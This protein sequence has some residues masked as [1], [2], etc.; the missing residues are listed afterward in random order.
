MKKLLSCLHITLLLV[1]IVACSSTPNTIGTAISATQ[2]A[3]NTAAVISQQNTLVA[4]ANLQMTQ[5]AAY[6]ILE[7]TH[8]AIDQTQSAL[9]SQQQ[10]QAA[11]AL[12]Q[13]V[14]M[15][16]PNPIPSL[17]AAGDTEATPTPPPGV[18][19][20]SSTGVDFSNAKILYPP[21]SYLGYNKLL[22]SIGLPDTVTNIP[23]KYHLEVAEKLFT[24]KTDVK[25]PN[26]LF[27][28]GN[29]P[30]G[31]FHA[32][33]LYED[34]G[35]VASLVFVSSITSPVWTPTFVRG[36]PPSKTPPR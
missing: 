24:C 8:V 28:I 5:S 26:R 17:A 15:A 11:I 23:G 7:Q 33:R 16:S 3:Q 9:S 19:P 18:N 6:Q 27:C 21:G 35:G 2:A 1:S 12:T 25:Y 13:A 4:I 31:G 14:I 34:I 30:R 10:I 36:G 32:V 22:L 20:R 29:N